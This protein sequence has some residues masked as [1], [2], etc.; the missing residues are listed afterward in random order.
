MMNYPIIY[1]RETEI[2]KSNTEIKATPD[3]GAELTQFAHLETVRLRNIA[4]NAY[5]AGDHKE[6]L[7]T[8]VNVMQNMK[9]PH[10]RREDSQKDGIIS[11]GCVQATFAMNPHPPTNQAFSRT[12]ETPGSKG[13]DAAVF[14][15]TKQVPKTEQHIDQATDRSSL[16]CEERQ[17]YLKVK[18]VFKHQLE[19]VEEDTLQSRLK[20][21]TPQELRTLVEPLIR[22]NI[23]GEVKAPNYTD[24]DTTKKIYYQT[25]DH[26]ARNILQEYITKI[27]QRDLQSKG[28]NT[29]WIDQNMELLIT[30]D[31]QHVITTWTNNSIDPTT[32]IAK[33]TKIRN[34]LQNEQTGELIIITPWKK[35]AT[36]LH[37]LVTRLNLRGIVVIPFNENEINKLINH[38]TIG[39]FLHA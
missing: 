34:E 26:E 33:L 12:V 29:R 3:K 9:E 37:S 6:A 39:A 7:R 35:D 38:I 32:T 23:I 31:N 20:T 11:K 19:I 15:R 36:K 2:Q 18:E 8:Y 4:D 25:T 16:D 17:T 27:V 10:G 1:D 5:K 13:Q 21:H 22:E 24:S 28:I 30:N 14:L